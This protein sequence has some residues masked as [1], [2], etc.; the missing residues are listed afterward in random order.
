M[1]MFRLSPPKGSDFMS[2][3]RSVSTFVTEY[4]QKKPQRILLVGS[5]NSGKSTLSQVL[6]KCLALPVYEIDD[7]AWQP[8]WRMHNL[9]IIRGRVA[10]IVSQDAW[11]LVGNYGSTQDISWPEADVVI[12]LDLPRHV[13][14]KRVILRCLHRVVTQTPV[15]N[16]NYETFAG[17]FL[18]K[19]S[20]VLWVWNHYHSIQQ[21][22]QNR[23]EAH[24]GPL[25]FR[26][27]NASDVKKLTRQLLHCRHIASGENELNTF[28]I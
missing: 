5:S 16:G 8:Q 27:R 19:D 21:R 12:W 11:I 28:V 17:S 15:C 4:E 22:Y 9:D 20:L 7:F 25:V 14:M 10:D 26:V 6:S 3:L 1:A 18:H 24:T 13:L 2:C 23:L